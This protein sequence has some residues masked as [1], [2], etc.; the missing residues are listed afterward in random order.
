MSFC[1]K[2]SVFVLEISDRK[3]KY[4]WVWARFCRFGSR[5]TA[6]PLETPLLLVIVSLDNYLRIF[7]H[8][9][10][11]YGLSPNEQAAVL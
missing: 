11:S 10:P 8:T 3:F 1:S 5:W 4:F 9:S 6:P 7:R 2:Y